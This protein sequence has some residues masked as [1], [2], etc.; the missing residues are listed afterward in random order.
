MAEASCTHQMWTSST[1]LPWRRT[2][3]WRCLGWECCWAGGKAVGTPA[4]IP[5][6]GAAS[7]HRLLIWGY[8]KGAIY[9]KVNN[10]RLN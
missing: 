5:G 3:A 1:C 9:P 7:E 8:Q 6:M 4:T 10:L 2:P